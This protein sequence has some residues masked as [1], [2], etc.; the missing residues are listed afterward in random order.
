MA[1]QLMGKMPMLRAKDGI[2]RLG[3]LPERFDLF[4][5]DRAKAHA[6]GPAA[7]RNSDSSPGGI[8]AVIGWLSVKYKASLA[9]LRSVSGWY[10]HLG[11]CFR[12]GSSLGHFC[13]AIAFNASRATPFDLAASMTRGPKLPW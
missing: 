10:Q 12:V 9:S 1:L 11:Y 13:F 5:R 4:L 8:A 7:S 2:E 3:H 6:P